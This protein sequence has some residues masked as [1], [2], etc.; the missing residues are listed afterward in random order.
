MGTNHSSCRHVGTQPGRKH[1]LPS[2][3]TAPG[4]LLKHDLP[5][6]GY[7]DL[8]VIDINTGERRSG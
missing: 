7:H 4:P 2:F 5:G 6:V 8:Y 1:A 3:P